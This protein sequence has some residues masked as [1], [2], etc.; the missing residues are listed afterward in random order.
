MLHTPLKIPPAHRKWRKLL[1]CTG[2]WSSSC[3]QP[4]RFRAAGWSGLT[5]SAGL[6]QLVQR[7][8]ARTPHILHPL[9]PLLCLTS[10][11]RRG[12]DGS[13]CALIPV[14]WKERWR[15]KR[16]VESESCVSPA[17]FEESSS[18]FELAHC[19]KLRALL[20][21]RRT[22]NEGLLTPAR[23]FRDTPPYQ[24]TSSSSISA[25]ALL[26]VSSLTFIPYFNPR[27]EFSFPSRA[28]S[29]RP[30]VGWREQLIGALGNH[31]DEFSLN[32]NSSVSATLYGEVIFCTLRCRRLHFIYRISLKPTQF[33]LFVWALSMVL[34]LTSIIRSS[35]THCVF[36]TTATCACQPRSQRQ[37]PLSL[38]TQFSLHHL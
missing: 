12:S 32:I 5:L 15:K 13:A 33:V 35:T 21:P 31:F 1:E 8:S 18:R 11:H 2:L 4:F 28:L 30:I 20:P 37:L 27:C 3:P 26:K 19:W 7:D 36:C 22:R 16:E 29:Q 14:R 6:G 34:I 9:L 25:G 23:L 17:G 10:A 38:R 24:N